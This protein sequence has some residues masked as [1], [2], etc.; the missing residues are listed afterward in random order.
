MKPFY[1]KLK[2]M[3]YNSKIIIYYGTHEFHC[4]TIDGWTLERL[5]MYVFKSDI[6]INT[7]YF[8]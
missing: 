1:I 2:E 5:I 6:K 7:K 3:L 4:N 8:T